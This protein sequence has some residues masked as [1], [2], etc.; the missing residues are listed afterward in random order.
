MPWAPTNSTIFPAHC[1][2]VRVLDLQMCAWYMF[3]PHW[4]ELDL[5]MKCICAP[6]VMRNSS[7]GV[8][9]CL[10]SI[11]WTWNGEMVSVL[12]VWVSDQ[13]QE[14]DSGSLGQHQMVDGRC[15]HGT[16]DL[17]VKSVSITAKESWME[18]SEIS[19]YICWCVQRACLRLRRQHEGNPSEKKCSFEDL[20][21]G[22]LFLMH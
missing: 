16:S 9:L 5:R 20:I 18:E 17:C 22:L 1:I 12:R 19:N 2:Q 14:A 13:C 8:V 4:F 6:L 21:S 3:I 10:Q 15:S 7:L 11:A